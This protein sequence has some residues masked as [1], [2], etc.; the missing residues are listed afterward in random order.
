MFGEYFNSSIQVYFI[1]TDNINPWLL[2]IMI[3]A[4]YTL[5]KVL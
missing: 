2:K 4:Q 5:N 1:D 3:M